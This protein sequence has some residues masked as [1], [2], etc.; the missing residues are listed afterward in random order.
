MIPQKAIEKA[1]ANV[2][3]L[4]GFMGRWMVTGQSPTVICDAGHNAGAWRLQSQ[5]LAAL[6]CNHLHMVLGFAADKDV[7]TVLSMMPK[8]VTYYF[9]QA[10][11]SRSMPA[12]TLQALG[13]EHELRGASYSKV[14][15]A[16]NAAKEAAEPDDVIFVGGSFYVL[17]ELFSQ[18]NA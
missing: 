7:A 12:P 4:T 6:A 1:F 13:I 5:Q 14:I 11:S 3:Q 2:C 10:Q 18:L 9:T 17:G 8:D 16:Y 15:D